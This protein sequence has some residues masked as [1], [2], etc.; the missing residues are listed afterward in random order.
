MENYIAGSAYQCELFITTSRTTVVS[1]KVDSPKWS[2]P[3]ISASFSITA[4]Q[5][6]QL[7]PEYKIRETGSRKES[8]GRGNLF[9]NYETD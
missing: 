5:V 1:V 8:K 7:M 6:K 3:K 9:D 4:V 2:S